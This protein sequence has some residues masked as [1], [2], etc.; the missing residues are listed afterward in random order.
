M[1]HAFEITTIRKL[2]VTQP[3]VRWHWN[4]RLSLLALLLL[5]VIEKY[6]EL[7]KT[8]CEAQQ[9]GSDM[10]EIMT[11]FVIE[12]SRFWN[13]LKAS[14]ILENGT[15]SYPIRSLSVASI[16]LDSKIPILDEDSMLLIIVSAIH[17][18]LLEVNKILDDYRKAKKSPD[19][20]KR[21]AGSNGLSIA[22]GLDGV[23]R[24]LGHQPMSTGPVDI[25]ARQRVAETLQRTVP[26][27]L[28]VL[29]IKKILRGSLAV[30]IDGIVSC[31]NCCPKLFKCP[32]HRRE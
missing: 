14:G 5:P 31:R 9:F 12:H 28:K 22:I 24:L 16:C 25:S 27:R 11:E 8:I 23:T 19:K 26:L 20:A 7:W 30:S 2:L 10:T 15:T 4:S 21:G 3:R 1:L 32:S 13:Y 6:L 29:L 18:L 17:T